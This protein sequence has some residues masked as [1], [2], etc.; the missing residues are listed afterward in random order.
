MIVWSLFLLAVIPFALAAF[1]RTTVDHDWARATGAS[2]I[3]GFVPYIVWSFIH[4]QNGGE[5]SG[6]ITRLIHIL[7]FA[8][9]ITVTVYAAT[10]FAK[11]KESPTGLVFALLLVALGL[12][13]IMVPELL[14]VDDSFSGA[15][16]RMNT[17]FKLYYQG[18][19][20]LAVAAGYA[21]HY[22]RSLTERTSGSRY[23]LTRVWAAAF[24]VLLVGAAYYP[25]AATATKGGLFSGEA[26]LNGL[27][28]LSTTSRDAIAFIRDTV[29][30]GSAVLEAFGEDYTE[31]GQVS[32]STGVP[33]VLGWVG[34]ELQWR[35]SSEL[36]EGREADIAAIY[37]TPDVEEAK[38]LL[39]RYSVDYVYIG[40][41][42]IEK[43]GKDG[44]AKFVE[45]MEPVF[46]EGNVT[47]YRLTK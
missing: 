47:I 44:L 6:I 38:N 14:F 8:L 7:P 10:W 9:L 22:W 1:W 41:R 4:M 33:T 46:T 20:V 43:Y 37:T 19:I 24:I 29:A 39:A 30:D 13:L 23:A 11:Q 45:F 36:M 31:F 34:H 12:L 42:E 16:E 26:S 27:S 25:L 15:F 18:W 32:A 5:T 2:A 40:P 35:G 17:V 3:V 21:V 28:H